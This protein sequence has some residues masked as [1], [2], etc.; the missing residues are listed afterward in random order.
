MNIGNKI[1]RQIVEANGNSFSKTVDY[2]A[3]KVQEADFDRDGGEKMSRQRRGEGQRMF[4]RN[5]WY[6]ANF[7]NA[8][9]Q[10]LSVHDLCIQGGPK[11][12]EWNHFRMENRPL[13][14]CIVTKMF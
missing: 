11:G 9:F 8:V 12:Q 7:L 4:Y 1:L 13:G 2:L 14:I 10:V 3:E 5:G 6:Y